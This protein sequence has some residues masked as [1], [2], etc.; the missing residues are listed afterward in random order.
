M[1]AAERLYICEQKYALLSWK[2][3]IEHQKKG[4][5]LARS[6]EV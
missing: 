6:S 4:R 5:V 3:D 2:D 1:L